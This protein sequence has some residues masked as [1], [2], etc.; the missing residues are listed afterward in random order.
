MFTS[1]TAFNVV[2]QS[3]GVIASGNTATDCAPIN[4]ATGSPYFVISWQGWG[5]GWAAGNAVRFNTDACLGPMWVVRTVLSGQGTVDDD[6]FKLQIR[7]DA[8]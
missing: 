5:T 4:P 8:D 6:Q 3:L 2:E 7:G 1:G